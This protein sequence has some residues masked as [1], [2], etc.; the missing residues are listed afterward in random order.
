MKKTLLSIASFMARVLPNSA[1]QVIYRI[2]PL[3]RLVRG[4]LNRAAPTGLTEVTVAAGGAAGL[5]MRLDLQ[6]E[7]DYWL[8]TY[9]TDL[10]A[11]IADLIQPDRATTPEI[12]YDIGANIGFVTLLLAQRI[13]ESGQIFAFEALP[14][15]LER[16]RTHVEINGLASRV[17][18]IPK[19][20]AAA[21]K[22]VRFLVGPSGAMGKTEESAGRADGHQE[23]L[24]VS[25][26]SLDDFVYRDGNPPPQVIKMDIEGG[27]VLALKGMQRLLAEAHPLILLELHG[28]EA[29]RVAWETLTAA[30]YQIRRMQRGYPPVPSIDTLD[31]KA[32]IVARYTE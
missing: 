13:E 23:S 17:H 31:W 2:D 16:L 10:Q 19:A 14:D 18:L 11:A 30:G 20:V 22:P 21:S 24:K 15:N 9:E 29:A 28:P 25:G 3:A 27:E 5:K 8:G 1:K 12:A 7:K 6:L 32:Y 4:T 26:I